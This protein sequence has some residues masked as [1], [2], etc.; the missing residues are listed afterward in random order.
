MTARELALARAIR[1][2]CLDCSGGVRAQVKACPVK[3]CPLYEFRCTGA[4]DVP[5]RA[6]A[7]VRDGLAGQVGLYEICG[8]ACG[9]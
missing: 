7:R 6:P 3:H 4:A 5:G 2:K 8:E 9:K 1:A